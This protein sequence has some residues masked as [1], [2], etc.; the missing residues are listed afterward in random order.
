MHLPNALDVGRGVVSALPVLPFQRYYGG[1]LTGTGSGQQQSRGRLPVM[2][3]G[4]AS[5]AAGQRY[6]AGAAQRYDGA[7]I[8][9]AWRPVLGVAVVNSENKKNARVVS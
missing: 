1:G 6:V 8:V 5:P 9:V 4:R 7:G 3:G 2:A